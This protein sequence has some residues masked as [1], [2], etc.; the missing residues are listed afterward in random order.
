MIHHKYTFGISH[1]VTPPLCHRLPAT[2]SNEIL[3]ALQSIKITD[4]HGA[5]VLSINIKDVPGGR[6]AAT[7]EAKRPLEF[8]QVRSPATPLLKCTPGSGESRVR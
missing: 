3:V 1:A 5:E 8:I 4:T 7:S 6:V 2:M